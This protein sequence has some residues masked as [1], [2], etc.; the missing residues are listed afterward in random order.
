MVHFFFFFFVLFT[1]VDIILDENT[2]CHSK[3]LF[4][5]DMHLG[6]PRMLGFDHIDYMAKVNCNRELR[7]VVSN[8]QGEPAVS[9]R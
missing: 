1:L 2:Y 9:Y 6:S 5:I 4:F 7:F 3:H 8:D